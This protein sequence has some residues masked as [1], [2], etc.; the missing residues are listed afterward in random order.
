MHNMNEVSIIC[1][2]MID[3]G[4]LQISWIRG[5]FRVTH[6]KNSLLCL[7]PGRCFLYIAG[8]ANFI[9]QGINSLKASI[10][11]F[12]IKMFIFFPYIY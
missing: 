6:R 2:S 3:I 9:I 11:F 12:K 10:E 7:K 5:S 1:S 8:C 4:C